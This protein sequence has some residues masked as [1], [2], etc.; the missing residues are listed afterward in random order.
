MGG[1]AGCLYGDAMKIDFEDYLW[2][3]F[4]ESETGKMTLDD[5]WP[6]AFSEWLPEQ[7]V[8]DIIKWANEWGKL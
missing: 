4:G 8:D 3:K 1:C 2:Q 7:D 5:E 6:D